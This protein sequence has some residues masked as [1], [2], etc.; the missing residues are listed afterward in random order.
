ME[1]CRWMCSSKPSRSR[2][3]NPH[4]RH[5]WT[6]RLSVARVG[7]GRTTNSEH[8]VVLQFALD[9]PLATSVGPGTAER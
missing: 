5:S 7:G 8:D 3:D 6:A 1:G 4:V 9:K 2:P